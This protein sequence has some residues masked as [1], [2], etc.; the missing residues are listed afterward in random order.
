MSGKITIHFTSKI[1]ATLFYTQL[2]DNETSRSGGLG[3]SLPSRLRPIE[4]ASQIAL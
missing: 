1:R 2:S 3:F 4:R